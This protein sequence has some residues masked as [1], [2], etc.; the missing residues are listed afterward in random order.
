MAWGGAEEQAAEIANGNFDAK[1][2]QV[3]AQ[4][5]VE[6]MVRVSLI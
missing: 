6:H 3:E 2:W 1:D 5:V 4:K